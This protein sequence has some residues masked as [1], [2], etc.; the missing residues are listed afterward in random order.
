MR[1]G[2]AAYTEQIRDAVFHSPGRVKTAEKRSS[3]CAMSY[4]RVIDR[5]HPTC[6][7]FLVDQS[8]A[9]ARAIEA[10][11]RTWAD[12]IADVT[13]RCLMSLVVRASRGDVVMHYLDIA[14]IGYGG[15]AGSAWGGTLEGRDWVS[16]PEIAEEP[17]RLVNTGAEG[18]GVIAPCWTKPVARGARPMK[19]AL[20]RAGELLRQWLAL[21][22]ASAGL[23]IFPPVVVNISGGLP[24]DGSCEET[25]EVAET[26]KS[27]S[28]DDGGVLLAGVCPARAADSPLTFPHDTSALN[29]EHVRLLFAMSSLVPHARRYDLPEGARLMV[30]T[31]HACR[32]L[33]EL[34]L[35]MGARSITSNPRS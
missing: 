26:L 34:L 20:I 33:F 3:A 10:E 28:T 5:R 22:A 7:V 21:R 14:V 15:S 13:N 18:R 31:S 24:T 30:S 11:G 1:S 6:A 19:E 17:L 32:V 23:D 29:A 12:V 4:T 9:M 2:L 35:E 27:V 16:L 8:A 25:L